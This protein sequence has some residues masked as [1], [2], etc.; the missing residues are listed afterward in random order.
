MVDKSNTLEAHE[1]VDLLA[2][3]IQAEQ[4]ERDH[5]LVG[6]L[7]RFTAALAIDPQRADAWLQVGRVYLK[8]ENFAEA[9]PALQTALTLQP[10]MPD[11]Q[12]ALAYA[13]YCMGQREQACEII[14]ALCRRSNSANAWSMRAYIR[15]HTDRDPLSALEVYRDWGRRFADPLT[16]K[17]KPLRV[18]DRNPRKR[19]KIG[20]VT[21]DFR[22]H[23]VAFFMLPVLQH[24]NPDNV[25]VHV[26]SNG[27]RDAFTEVIQQAVPH[28]HEVMGITDE[29]LCER[30]RADGIDVLV[31]LSGHTAGHRLLTF[32]RRAAPVQ[33]TWLGFMQ[34]LGMKA[35]DYRLVDYGIAPQGHEKY[36][37][38]T[39]FRLHCMASYAPPAYAPLGEEPP[40]LRNGY[41]TLISLNS[42]AK[43]T[44]AMLRVWARILHARTDARL[45][46]MVKE[47]TADAAQ[48]HM[49]PR[50]E[51]AGMPLDR[52][53]VL[54]QQPL[55]Q[56]MELGHIADVALDTA[57]VS[58]GTTT[59]H[60]LWMGLT[61]VALDADR[62]VDASTART[63]QGLGFG[64]EIAKDEQ[65]YVDAALR[66]M[67]DP[68]HL[69]SRRRAQRGE[70]QRSVL[71]D[72]PARTA[73][74]EKAYRLMWLNWLNAQHGGSPQ[75]L[76]VGADLPA[77]IA[78]TEAA[79]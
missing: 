34:P 42:S 1:E 20:Y 16:R 12:H 76:S 74:V 2:N 27:R 47:R 65:A 35:M 55:A 48:A 19:L 52:V 64:G 68:E 77:L 41:P 61:I 71:M 59:L 4:S 38:E 32:A 49:Q 39:L 24:H 8:M 37:S 58:G 63:L 44:D 28:W 50:V 40:M 21:A 5:D 14:D 45:I 25:E 15:S 51:A 66:L 69:A 9:V 60:A 78:A 22:Q 3:L 26:Y 18:A 57:P 7:T 46:I 56:F 31:D 67:N 13:L 11:A 36:Y 54:H 23:S 6:A 62:G 10:G 79:A 70:L 33:V 72:Y 43:I 75:A 30:I 53:F 73:E 17:A 29:A